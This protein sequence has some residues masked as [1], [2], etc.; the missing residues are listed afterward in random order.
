MRAGD[1]STLQTWQGGRREK[2]IR[3]RAIW[4]GFSVAHKKHG[5]KPTHHHLPNQL[6]AGNHHMP[7]LGMRILH[8]PSTNSTKLYGENGYLRNRG[9]FKKGR[10]WNSGVLYLLVADL[11]IK[12][13]FSTP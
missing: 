12:L 1:N 2:E 3:I 11:S 13:Y 6:Q 7:D 4:E 5:S 9:K 10:E 8:L